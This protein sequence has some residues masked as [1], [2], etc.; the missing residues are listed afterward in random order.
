MGSEM[1]I[2]DRL[3]RDGLDRDDRISAYGTSGIVA[4]FVFC[5]VAS[6]F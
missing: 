1:C 2:R 3:Y 5:M 4:F 6:L